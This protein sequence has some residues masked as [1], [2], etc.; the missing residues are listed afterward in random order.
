TTAQP[1]RGEDSASPQGVAD[2][3][4]CGILRT[5]R[6]EPALP[7]D[8]RRKRQLVGAKGASNAAFVES[9]AGN[10]DLADGPSDYAAPSGGSSRTGG[11]SSP[12][13]ALGGAPDSLSHRLER[14]QRRGVA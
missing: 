9:H 11:A 1:A 7:P 8:Q 6:K 12:L 5:C 13:A 10:G 14:K 4:V 3:G 2:Q